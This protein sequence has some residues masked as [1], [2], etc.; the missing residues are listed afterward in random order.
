MPKAFFLSSVLVKSMP[1]L[2]GDKEL[3]K[4]FERWQE[5]R[6]IIKKTKQINIPGMDNLIFIVSFLWLLARRILFFKQV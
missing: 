5:I 6:V 2:E 4:V 3:N 1:V